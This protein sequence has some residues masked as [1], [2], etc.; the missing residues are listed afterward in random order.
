MRFKDFDLKEVDE[1][2][3]GGFT[4]YAATFDREPDS[5]GD[6][7]AKG[8]FAA[9]LEAW[10]ESGRPVPLLYGH[11]MD[12]PDYNI[13][14][15]ELVEDERGLL[16]RARFDSSPKAQRVREL[17]REGRLDQVRAT[18]DG[19][20]YLDDAGSEPT[21]LSEWF[22]AGVAKVCVYVDSEQDLLDVAEQAREKGFVY[23]LIRD[24]GLTEFHGEPTYTCLAIEPLPA[25]VLDPITGSLPL[26]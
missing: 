11:N 21:A 9:T 2:G 1:S 13:G 8:A 26:Y 12:D 17:V 23:S 4:G 15:A 7:I 3:D 25:D 5:Y 24:A 10:R 14:T 22:E 6:V 18:D 19:W 20:V 16:A